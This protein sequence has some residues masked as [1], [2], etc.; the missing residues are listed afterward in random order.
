MQGIPL[1]TIFDTI[2]REEVFSEYG[3]GGPPY[4][5]EDLMARE[6]TQGLLPLIGTLREREAEGLR[7]MVRTQEWK[8]VHDPL[9]DKDELYHLENDADELTNVI[10]DKGYKDV[11]ADMQRRLMDWSIRNEPF[12]LNR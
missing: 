4:R 7:K 3:A 11:V 8:Y 10:D 2:P 5:M 1:P 9:G 6:V 12:V